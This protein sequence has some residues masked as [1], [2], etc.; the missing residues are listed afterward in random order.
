MDDVGRNHL[1]LWQ[2]PWMAATLTAWRVPSRS[3][4]GF[5]GRRSRAER[6]PWT[7]RSESCET[8]VRHH[9]ELRV[10]LGVASL[11]V[12]PVGTVEGHAG[13]AFVLVA[14]RAIEG[15]LAGR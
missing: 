11:A 14:E 10:G 15:Q 2:R 1:S 13:R 6:R 4:A 12:R 7:G 3:R 8:C 9:E 5:A